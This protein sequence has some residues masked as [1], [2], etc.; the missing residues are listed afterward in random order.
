MNGLYWYNLKTKYYY[1]GGIID[2]AGKPFSY[3]STLLKILKSEGAI[4]F[5]R[6][7]MP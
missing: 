6:G 1:K 3:D 4:P 2:L 5:V 7:N